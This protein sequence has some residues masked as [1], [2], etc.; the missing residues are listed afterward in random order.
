MTDPHIRKL[1]RQVTAA[2]YERD[3]LEEL[4]RSIPIE[5]LDAGYIDRIREAFDRLGL[6]EYP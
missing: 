4:I 6:P 3:Q 2:R 1:T 5:D